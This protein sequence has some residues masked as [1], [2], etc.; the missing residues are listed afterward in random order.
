MRSNRRYSPAF[1]C[2]QVRIAPSTVVVGPPVALGPAPSGRMLDDTG[3]P[4]SE[5]TGEGSYP[6]ILTSPTGTSGTGNVC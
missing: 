1:D 6:I 2:L 3:S 5:P 4:G